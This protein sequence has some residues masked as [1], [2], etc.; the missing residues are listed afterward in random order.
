MSESQGSEAQVFISSVTT[1]STSFRELFSGYV[2]RGVYIWDFRF[3][4]FDFFGPHLTFSRRLAERPF[5]TKGE[6]SEQAIVDFVMASPEVRRTFDAVM[7]MSLMDFLTS[8]YSILI[9]DK[10]HVSK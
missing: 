7:P 9:L 5:I 8:I 4:L 1:S 3:P 6:M 2:S 10:I